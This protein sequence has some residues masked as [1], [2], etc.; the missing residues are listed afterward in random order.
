MSE[1]EENLRDQLSWGAEEAESRL[2]LLLN[3]DC[4]DLTE[5]QRAKH[6]DTLLIAT[7][8]FSV[9]KVLDS[10]DNSIISK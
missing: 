2:G 9:F 1:Y 8:L 7:A 5:E 4:S 10:I 6:A 3:D